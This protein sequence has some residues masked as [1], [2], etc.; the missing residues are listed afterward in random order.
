MPFA[1]PEFGRLC[2][3]NGA[4]SNPI[5][6]LPPA[7]WTIFIPSVIAP[8]ALSLPMLAYFCFLRKRGSSL[9]TSCTSAVARSWV[10]GDE[11]IYQGQLHQRLVRFNHSAIGHGA[12]FLASA[13]KDLLWCP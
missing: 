11:A 12:A 9:A 5:P 6:L 3:A 13:V 4:L 8:K 7:P 2:C 1:R 10:I